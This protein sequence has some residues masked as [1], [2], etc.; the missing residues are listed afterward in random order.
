MMITL[1]FLLFYA[2]AFMLLAAAAGVIISRH[3]M[4]SALSLVLAF[5]AATGLW[6]LAETEFLALVLILVY[7]GAVMTLFLFVVMTLNLDLEPQRT[8]FV[9]YLPLGIV[10]MAVTTGLMLYVILP[11]QAPN[12]QLIQQPF[13][14]DYS[15][16]KAMGEVL[17]TRYAYPFEV[18]GALLL[19][20]IVAA[21]SLSLRQRKDKKSQTV[22]QQLAANPRERMRLVSMKA[23][24]KD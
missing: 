24:K 11:N 13:P 10:V 6:L 19:V 12:W 4:R 22:S 20:A 15:N 18:A 17:F 21:I 8:G 7:V 3:T 14:A 9:K 16:V 5:F 23:E 1:P 2:F